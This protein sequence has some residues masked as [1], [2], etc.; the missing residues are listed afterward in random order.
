MTDSGSPKGK[1]TWSNPD[2]RAARYLIGKTPPPEVKEADEFWRDF[3]SHILDR[4]KLEELLEHIHRR[5]N[6]DFNEWHKGL[7]TCADCVIT[8]MAWKKRL[9]PLLLSFHMLDT[10]A[11]VCIKEFDQAAGSCAT[12]KQWHETTANLIH[13]VERI[14][15]RTHKFTMEDIAMRIGCQ[16][17]YMEVWTKTP[18]GRALATV[19]VREWLQALCPP[20]TCCV[21][22]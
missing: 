20:T 17:A 5:C 6:H 4:Y 12:P 19:C 3:V 7:F 22:M 15:Q 21:V 14:R 9:E 8:L 10:E 13:L 18:Q 11:L 2:A 1:Y 16:T